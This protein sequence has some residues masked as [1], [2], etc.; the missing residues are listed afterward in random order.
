MRVLES[1]IILINIFLNTSLLKQIR[2]AFR[3]DTKVPWQK[4]RMAAVESELKEHA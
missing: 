1:K 4:P 3:Y 2:A